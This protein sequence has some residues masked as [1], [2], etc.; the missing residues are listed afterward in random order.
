MNCIECVGGSEAEV[1]RC[2]LLHCP[3][4]PYRLASNPFHRQALTEAERVARSTRAKA[5][6]ASRPKQPR[7]GAATS[8]DNPLDAGDASAGME[9]AGGPAAAGHQGL[10]LE[11][12]TRPRSG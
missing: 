1:R 12:R 10:G 8:E 5:S 3:F 7:Q 9:I 4:W 6:R 11:Q 2:R